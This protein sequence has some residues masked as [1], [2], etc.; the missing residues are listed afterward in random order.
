[1]AG[2]LLVRVAGVTRLVVESLIADSD[3]VVGVDGFDI[4]R[5]FLDPSGD[6]SI[7]GETV[8]FLL[9]TRFEQDTTNVVVPEAC[10]SQFNEIQGAE[11]KECEDSQEPLVV[12][13]L[14]EHLGSLAIQGRRVSRPP[15]GRG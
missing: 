8:S 11:G 9:S 7:C 4:G 1:V 2:Y 12:P 10:A 15:L 13:V 14:P 5:D 6:R 3:Q